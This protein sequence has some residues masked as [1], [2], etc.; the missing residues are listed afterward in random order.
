MCV[1]CAVGSRVVGPR[2]QRE[3]VKRQ[4]ALELRFARA[5]VL[6]SVAPTVGVDLTC[7]LSSVSFHWLLELDTDMLV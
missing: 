6:W 7:V 2:Q 3:E 5:C 4:Q 1:V